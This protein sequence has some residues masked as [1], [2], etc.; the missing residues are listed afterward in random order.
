MAV[1][2]MDPN[3]GSAQILNVIRANASSQYQDRIPLATR[4][5]IAEVGNAIVNYEATKNEFL[6]ALVNRIGLV[7]ITSRMAENPLR[8]FKKGMLEFGKD[9]EEVFVELA[10]AHTYDPAVAETQVFK[11]EIPDVSA[12]FH[13][14]NRQDFYKVTISNDQLRT[15]FLSYRGIE[16]LI[17]RIVDSLYSGDNYDEFILM[18]HLVFD[19]AEKGQFYPV[20]V[21]APT[22]DATGKQLVTA[23]REMSNNLTFM[24]NKYN[25]MGVT[26]YTPREDQIV[27]INTAAD[28]F[29]DVNV[30]AS[31]FNMD[32]ANFLGQR[33]LIDD[34]GGLNN[35][36]AAI[37]DRNWFMVFD[38]YYNMTEQ[39][40]GEGLY[41]NYWFHHWQILSTSLFANAVIFVTEPSTVTS[42][43]VTPGTLSVAKPPEGSVVNAQ[44]TANVVTTGMAP[45]NVTW[46]LATPSNSTINAQGLVTI[47]STETAASLTVTATSIFDSTKTGTATITLT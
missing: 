20:T 12:I 32:K 42:V 8:M 2:G 24:S 21:P 11:R 41:W 9:V 25:A 6:S 22:D 27:L 47:P 40:N 3:V 1:K 45:S 26:T 44:F 18:K 16:D 23:M 46:S 36:V 7:L 14:M 28:A 43:T 39:Y 13:R 37:V 34:F 10:K 38:T 33:V 30:L 5:N 4:N 19:A 29:I 31:A 17:G 35:V 15:A